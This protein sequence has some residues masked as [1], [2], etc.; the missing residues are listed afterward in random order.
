LKF[1]KGAEIT[2]KKKALKGN[3]ANYSLSIIND[4]DPSMQLSNSRFVSEEK[5]ISLIN[6]K[7][8]GLK[9]GVTLKVEMKKETEDGIINR[10]L[11]FNSIAKTVTHP[12]MIDS[13]IREAEE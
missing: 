9:F 11:Y 12:D 5:L 6:E 3:V 1:I 13:L 2:E 7:R 8:K 10:E 4:K